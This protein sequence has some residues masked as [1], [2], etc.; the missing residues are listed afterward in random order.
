[1]ILQIIYQRSVAASA[2]AEAG[3][4]RRASRR[5]A[6]RQRNNDGR[7]LPRAKVE[8]AFDVTLKSSLKPPIPTSS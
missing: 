4:F 7:K 8:S 3:G 6:A 5:C 1:M 2:F